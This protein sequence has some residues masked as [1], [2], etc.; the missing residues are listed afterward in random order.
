MTEK[1][2][3]KRIL[4]LLVMLLASMAL[5]WLLWPISKILAGF[6][7]ILIMAS[8]SFQFSSEKQ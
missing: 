4:K 5:A 3:Q 2:N 7:F 6:V 1:T 8:A